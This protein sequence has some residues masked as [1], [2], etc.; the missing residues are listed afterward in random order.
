M[1]RIIDDDLS[2]THF[3]ICKKIEDM[4][5]NNSIEMKRIE[6]KLSK[7]NIKKEFVDIGSS[8][9]VQS[10]G[11]YTLK[12]L[13]TANKDPLR[14]DCIVAGFCCQ[15]KQYNSCVYRTL[16]INPTNSQERNY[17]KVLALNKLLINSIKPKMKI[18]ALYALGADFLKQELP[19]FEV[20]TNFGYGIGLEYKENSLLINDKND[21]VFEQG[22]TIL[23]VTGFKDLKSGDK[24]YALLLTDVVIVTKDG[25]EPT[26]NEAEKKLDEISFSIEIDEAQEKKKAAKKENVENNLPDRRRRRGREEK[27]GVKLK[28]LNERNEHQQLLK[29]KKLEELKARVNENFSISKTKIKEIP[30]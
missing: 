11:N 20:P 25:V 5:D 28:S 12:L 27:D 8:A 16:L 3:E 26:T 4:F 14:S 19:D 1:K 7:F 17:E 13:T 10:G 15:Y 24:K 23:I 2:S 22:M 29:E 21:R 9:I 18:S 30:Y 6:A